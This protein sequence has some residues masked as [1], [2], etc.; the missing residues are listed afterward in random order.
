MNQLRRAIADA[1]PVVNL[2]DGRTI[3]ESDL[4]ELRVVSAED[5]MQ[6][7]IAPRELVLA[8]WLELY[9]KVGDAMN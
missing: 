1:E 8:P 2:R 9:P 6:M 4:P 7:D 3:S 5:F